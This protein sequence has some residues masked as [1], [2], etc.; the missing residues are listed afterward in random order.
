MGNK[1]YVWYLSYGSNIN[2]KRFM[3][4]ILGKKFLPTSRKP[5]RCSD[6]T[7]PK[8][9][10][11]HIFN[12]PLLFV[13][14]AKQWDDMGV[15]IINTETNENITTYGKMYLITKE[16]FRHVTKEENGGIID[17]ENFSFTKEGLTPQIIKKNKR[18]GLL[19]N[20]GKHEG[21][22]IYTFTS[23]K[24]ISKMDINRPSK[25]YIKAISQG[26]KEGYKL[27]NEQIVDYFLQFKGVKN[28]YTKDELINLIKEL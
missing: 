13:E 21:F 6:A 28:L 4:Y 15:A 24:N 18:C 7:P 19:L 1:E 9:I 27:S 23:S 14:K 26:I 11:Y 5:A 2:Y 22:P 10:K 25:K 8:D 16:Q 20:V 12:N 17:N 3:C